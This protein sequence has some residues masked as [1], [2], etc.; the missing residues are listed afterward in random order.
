MVSRSTS[1]KNSG[2]KFNGEAALDT[3][4]VVP[5]DID[6]GTF[7]CLVVS[8]FHLDFSGTRSIVPDNGVAPSCVRLPYSLI[9]GMDISSASYQKA[10]SVLAKQACQPHDPV[11]CS[12]LES[13]IFRSLAKL[14]A[15]FLFY[16]FF[17]LP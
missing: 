6:T 15:S 1:F 13:E 8:Y 4:P 7:L 17:S 12:K 9:P 11:P 10:I 14:G 3:R 2:V 16:H 5:M